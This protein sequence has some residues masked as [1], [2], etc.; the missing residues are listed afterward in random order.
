MFL[1]LHLP[2]LG[3]LLKATAT[4][5][6][7]RIEIISNG[8]SCLQSGDDD[9]VTH[10]PSLVVVIVEQPAMTIPTGDIS[11]RFESLIVWQRL[12]Q[13]RT[14]LKQDQLWVLG[15][16]EAILT[17]AHTSGCPRG[18]GKDCWIF[19]AV[20]LYWAFSLAVRLRCF[21]GKLLVFR[22]A[23]LYSSTSKVSLKE[24]FRFFELAL[25]GLGLLSSFLCGRASR[26]R[27]FLFFEAFVKLQVT[28]WRFGQVV[29]GAYD[30]EVSS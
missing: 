13:A 1:L 27:S 10:V 28:I 8:K 22:V 17:S 18:S 21:F 14:V 19:A 9:F 26:V 30:I 2:S 7:I 20:A 15:I 6:E 5:V 24:D 12:A 11:T 23:G 3:V 16:L 25:L 29:M 4:A